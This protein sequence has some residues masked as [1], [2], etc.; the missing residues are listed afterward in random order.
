MGLKRDLEIEKKRRLEQEAMV[1]HLRHELKKACEFN[2]E[3][4]ELNSKMHDMATNI[5]DQI[6]PQHEKIVNLKKHAMELHQK[7]GATQMQAAY[8]TLVEAGEY[9]NLGPIVSE[10]LQGDQAGAASAKRQ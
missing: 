3:I 5:V 2:N 1:K 4:R 10:M 7:L 9:D 8:H 6:L